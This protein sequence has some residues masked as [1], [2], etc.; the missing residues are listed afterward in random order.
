MASRMLAE[1][2]RG[3]E[4]TQLSPS[5]GHPEGPGCDAQASASRWTVLQATPTRDAARL[6]PEPQRTSRQGPF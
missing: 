6:S 5:E 4:A 2:G 3:L 1:A